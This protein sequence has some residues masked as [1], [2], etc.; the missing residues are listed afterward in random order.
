MSNISKKLEQIEKLKK[1]LLEEKE[2]IENTLGKELISQ[3]DLNYESLTKNEIKEFVNN[4]KDSYDLMNEDQSL[5][6][7]NSVDSPTVG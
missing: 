5:N 4:L 2:K 3:F 6:S 1:E 7:S